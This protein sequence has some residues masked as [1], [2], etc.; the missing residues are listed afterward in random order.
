MRSTKT[1]RNC[2]WMSVLVF[3][4]F[5][6]IF[7]GIGELQGAIVDKVY[8]G[9][10]QMTGGSLTVTLPNQVNLSK[11]FLTFS[12]TVDNN[13]PSN[14]LVVGY[15]SDNETKLLRGLGLQQLF[16]LIGMLVNLFQGLKLNNQQ[17]FKGQQLTQQLT[18]L[19]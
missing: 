18:Q 12:S 17:F 2:I 8:H 11:S 1:L 19:I 10:S 9:S 5:F 3:S 14:F 6:S 4:M 16:L 7:L 13:G 15:M